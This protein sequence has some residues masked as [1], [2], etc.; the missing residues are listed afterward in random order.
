MGRIREW[1][2]LLEIRLLE[3]LGLYKPVEF[4][5]SRLTITYNVLS[6][7]KLKALVMGGHVRGWDDP[8]LYT[9]AGLRRRGVTPA[10]MN[11]FCREMGITRSDNDIPV[12]RFEHH[13]RQDLDLNSPRTMAVLRPLKVI[14]PH[15][16]LFDPK[17]RVALFRF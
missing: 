3:V 9:L 8:R 17:G 10:A 6:K 5:Y 1:L 12:H 2:S 16:S 11:S 13:I 4:E 7:R 15:S 14:P